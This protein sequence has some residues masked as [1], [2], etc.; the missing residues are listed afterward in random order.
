M[1]EYS[2]RIRLAGDTKYEAEQN[3][4]R[5]SSHSVNLGSQ[6]FMRTYSKAPHY[7]PHN[8]DAHI[9]TDRDEVG[10]IRA[11]SV[12]EGSLSARHEKFLDVQRVLNAKMAEKNPDVEVEKPKHLCLDMPV[13][14]SS[15]FNMLIRAVD[16]FVVELILDER[17]ERKAEKLQMLHLSEEEWRHVVLFTRILQLFDNAQQEFSSSAYPSLQLVIPALE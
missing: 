4:V 7:D 1:V 14:W 2:F 3:R 8:P 5:C 11:I 10:I 12:K 13:R 15:T 16:R 9:P 17:D 6:K